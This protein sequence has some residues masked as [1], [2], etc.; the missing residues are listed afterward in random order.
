MLGRLF[1]EGNTPTR[2][3]AGGPEVSYELVYCMAPL[4]PRDLKGHIHRVK[5]YGGCRG[6][7]GGDAGS[8]PSVGTRF[9]SGKVDHALEIWCAVPVYGHKN[10]YGVFK[11][12]EEGGLLLLKARMDKG[13]L[14]SFTQ[15]LEGFL[16]VDPA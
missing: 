1:E 16:N 8:H 7:G 14:S 15:G 4:I 11:L 12:H 5:G 10:T 6:L 9:L 3:N 13:G 2:G